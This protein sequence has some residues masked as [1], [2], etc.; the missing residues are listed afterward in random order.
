M[1]IFYYRFPNQE[2]GK[3]SS[4]V[5]VKNNEE[6]IQ[7]FF[8]SE[9]ILKSYGHFANFKVRKNAN[10]NKDLFKLKFPYNKAFWDTQ[11]QLLLTDEMEEFI[12]KV[13]KSGSEFKIR[14]NMD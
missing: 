7:T 2:N 11:N 3:I 4:I 14:T 12:E 13:G 8:E 5:E 9:D 6:T 1:G 10:E